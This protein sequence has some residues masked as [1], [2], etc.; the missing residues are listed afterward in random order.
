[1]N[2]A[3][4]LV[5]CALNR[6]SKHARR[7]SRAAFAALLLAAALLPGAPTAQEPVGAAAQP[8]MESVASLRPEV[9]LR[10]LHLVRPDLI[11]YPLSYDIFC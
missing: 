7:L 5:S 3:I 2:V 10:K 11:M 4:R 1:M 8:A 6:T 9:R